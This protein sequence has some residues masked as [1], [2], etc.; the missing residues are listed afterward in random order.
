MHIHLKTLLLSGVL[1]TMPDIG[2][3]ARQ[4]FKTERAVS[5]TYKAISHGA[6][7]IS[8][9]FIVPFQALVFMTIPIFF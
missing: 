1:L 2:K 3:T 4:Y 5:L 6:N 8:G 9:H 7:F